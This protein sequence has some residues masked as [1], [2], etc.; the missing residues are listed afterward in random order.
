MEQSDSVR[1]DLNPRNPQSR[2]CA[3]MLLEVVYIGLCSLNNAACVCMVT[4][5]DSAV[6]NLCDFGLSK[7][8]I[9]LKDAL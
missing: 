8:H 3:Q 1:S 6:F 9:K 7:Q 5:L 2:H 4:Y